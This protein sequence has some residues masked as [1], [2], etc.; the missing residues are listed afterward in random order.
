[1]VLGIVRRLYLDEDEEEQISYYSAVLQYN[2]DTGGDWSIAGKY[3]VD[4]I[5][6]VF[7][8]RWSADLCLFG[9]SVLSVK[10]KKY[11]SPPWAASQSPCGPYSGYYSGLP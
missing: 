9:D 1:M 6:P 3:T 5:D 8:E 7:G 2:T 4:T 11:I 10:M